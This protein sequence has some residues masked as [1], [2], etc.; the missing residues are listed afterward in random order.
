MLVLW[1]CCARVGCSP[2]P[3]SRVLLKYLEPLCSTLE[4]ALWSRA[5]HYWFLNAGPCGFSLQAPDPFNWKNPNKTL[6]PQWSRSLVSP[7]L[8]LTSCPKTPEPQLSQMCSYLPEGLS[9]YRTFSSFSAKMWPTIGNWMKNWVS[10]LQVVCTI[11]HCP[12]QRHLQC[13]HWPQT[14]NNITYCKQMA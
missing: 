4:P 6:H 10:F 7:L 1:Y 14:R 3:L 13:E 2:S 8:E 12:G 5:L 11:V 9:S